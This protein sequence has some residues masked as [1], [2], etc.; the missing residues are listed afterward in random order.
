L[1]AEEFQPT[2]GVTNELIAKLLGALFICPG[3]NA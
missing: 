3:Q 1:P 2:L